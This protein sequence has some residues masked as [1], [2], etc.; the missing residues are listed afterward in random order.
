MRFF[1]LFLT[2]TTATPAIAAELV[3]HLDA[4]A[5]KLLRLT[6]GRVETWTGVGKDA[7][8]FSQSDSDRR[9]TPGPSVNNRAT[10]HFDGGDFLE[11]P[12]V[13]AEGDDTFTLIALWKPHRVAIQAVIEQ[14]GSGSGAR[15]SLLQVNGRYGFNGQGNDFHNALPL[16]ANEWRLSA[17][18]VNGANRDNVIVI[19][20]DSPPAVG[21]INIDTQNVGVDG[22]IIGRKLKA[23]GEFFQGDIAE[24]LIFDSA[25]SKAELTEQL[26]GL[27]KRWALK[28]ESKVPTIAATEKKTPVAM[29]LNTKPTDEQ[30][31]FF[32]SKV[33]PLLIEH[34]Y[35]CHSKDSKRLEAD[36]RL[37]GN[38]FALKGGDSGPA[39]VPGNPADSLLIQAV[40]WQSYE[41]PPKGKLSDAHIA[42]LER[43]VEMGAPWP[44]L[45]SSALAEKT[46]DEPYDWEKFR[47]E[48]WA[49]RPVE[50]GE[51]PEVSDHNWVRS[52]ID[53]FV[54]ARLESAGL[55][56][57]GPATRRTLIR[58]LYFDLTGLPPTPDQVAA[59]LNDDSPDAVAKVIN[60]LLESEHY[61]ERWARY[62]LD[63]ARYS[64]GMGGFLDNAA[65]PN[66]WRY[67]DW[68]VRALNDDMP[69]NEFVRRQI[70]GDVLTET[71]DPVGTGFF[72]VGPTYRGDG[73]DPK[74]TAEAKA[75]TLADRVDTFSRAFLG[76]TAACARCHDHKFDPVTTKDYYAIAGVFNNTRL[77][78]R[79]LGSKEVIDAYNKAQA[80]VKQQNA[81]IQKFLSEEAKRLSKKPNQVEKL[82]DDAKKSTLATM[83]EELKRRQQA[84]PPKPD[85]A[86]TLAEAGSGDMHVAIRGDLRKKGDP[87]P[88]RFLQI[89]AGNDSQRFTQG[90]GRRELAEAVVD[91]ANPL[92][93]RVIVNRIWQ[94]HFGEGIVRSPS[95]F[96]VLGQQPTHP[97]L[98]DWLA[99]RFVENDWSLKELHRE[100]LLS[101]TWQMSSG[102]DRQKFEQDGDNRLIWRSNPRRLAVEVWRDGLLAVTGE[103][104]RTVGGA[105]TVRILDVPR[106]TM[107]ATVSRNGDR[108]DSDAFLRL[109]DFP[110]PRSTIAQRA[111]S[112]VPQQ[113]LFM[114]N[115]PFMQRRAAALSKDLAQ[116]DDNQTRIRAAYERLYSRPPE[117]RELSVGLA[118]L[119]DAETSSDRWPQYAQVLL[120]AHEFQ[121]IR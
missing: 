90:S 12:A 19:D 40:K 89:V 85:E 116:M 102:F 11:G 6:D 77:A 91:P 103:L 67:R 99:A 56:P 68:V 45:N 4:S 74:A 64:D 35:E 63:V 92:T 121:Q 30:V 75:E 107:Y 43:W 9:P 115:S 27:K 17:I 94:W 20:N 15:A 76:L 86:H 48:H 16:Q 41:M 114:L 24:V 72:A 66:A 39:V 111:I 1:V 46:E 120:S 54:L 22:T 10:L 34:C 14:A 38:V 7:P 101:A 61:G 82:L 106:R 50:V 33:R 3:L 105:P 69:Y 44:G 95:N 26:A 70:A 13:L 97:Q 87:A 29:A 80:S 78:V 100:I 59:F 52:P 112:T 65:L 55:K 25:L 18:V 84:I 109:F 32:E 71:P 88:R 118:F 58:R 98:L 60:E 104:D 83:R 81:T 93:A 79:Q 31:A 23:N 57:N 28:F 62:W 36:L 49:F 113:Y 5:A 119:G 53:Q 73:G 117:D 42:T 37:D 2:L 110:S 51:L 47:T 96:G 108:Y 8:G 21:T